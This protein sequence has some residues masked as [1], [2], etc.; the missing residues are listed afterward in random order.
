[1]AETWEFGGSALSAEPG[2]ASQDGTVEWYNADTVAT[3]QLRADFQSGG[4]WALRP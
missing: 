2:L 1:M 4:L 3:Y